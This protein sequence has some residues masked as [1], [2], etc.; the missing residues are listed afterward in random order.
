MIGTLF[1]WEWTARSVCLLWGQ[2]RDLQLQLRSRR[3]EV[4]ALAAEAGA[5]GVEYE[6]LAEEVRRRPGFPKPM[7]CSWSYSET[8][9]MQLVL[10]RNQW[11]AV[12]PIPKP[13]G[14]SWSYS[15]RRTGR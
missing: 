13:M 9:G 12:G 15:A 5:R 6:R 14:C 4:E 7:G 11:D 1:S 8:N 3:D 2:V 10:F